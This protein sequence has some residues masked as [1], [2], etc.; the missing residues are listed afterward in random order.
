MWKICTKCGIE[1]DISEFYKDKTKKFGVRSECKVC[2]LEQKKY[3]Y[4]NNKEK[5]ALKHKCYNDTHKGQKALYN[6][7]YYENNKEYYYDR[8]AK[9]RAKKLNQT[10]D[11]T[12]AEQDLINYIY[13]VRDNMNAAAG[14]IKYH[15]DHIIPIDK[16][17]LHHPNNLQIL[18]AEDN[19]SKGAK[20][21]YKYKGL[22]ISLNEENTSDRR[23]QAGQTQS[24]RSGMGFNTK[25]DIRHKKRC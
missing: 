7:H 3:Y 23:R 16:G 12:Q 6:K 8:E 20:L 18:T 4:D 1:K 13:K 22:R 21:Y 10:P 19:L 9:R 11:L 24:R 2:M 25:R 14:Y 5:V 15:V 17:G